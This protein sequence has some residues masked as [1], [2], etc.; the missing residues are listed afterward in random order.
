MVDPTAFTKVDSVQQQV[1]TWAGT[2]PTICDLNGEKLETAFVDG[3][4]RFGG[5]GMF[6]VTCH[7]Q[8]GIGLGT[9]R[10]Q[11]YEKQPSGVWLKTGG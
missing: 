10:G 9:G 2:A 3:R 11:K 6:C 5:W 4:L 8:F 1:R 7:E